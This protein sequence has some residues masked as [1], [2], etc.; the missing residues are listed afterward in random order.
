MYEQ[1]DF[2]RVSRPV[3]AAL[4]SRHGADTPELFTALQVE[5]IA[6]IFIEDEPWLVPPGRLWSTIREVMNYGTSSAIAEIY[7]EVRKILQDRGEI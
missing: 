5:E 4:I 3:W 7:Q 6:Q 1:N 2:Q